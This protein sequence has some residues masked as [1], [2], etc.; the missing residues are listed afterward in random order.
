MKSS[1][2]KANPGK[3]RQNFGPSFEAEKHLRLFCDATS[4]ELATVL[5]TLVGELDYALSTTNSAAKERS[6]LTAVA[7]AER[8]LSLARNLRY[9][10]VHTQLNT[11]IHDVSQ[12]VLDSVELVEKELE[13]F[14]IKITVLAEAATYGLVDAGA[15]QQIVLNLLASARRTMPKGGTITLSLRRTENQIELK[16]ADTGHGIPEREI[17]TMFEPYAGKKTDGATPLEGLFQVHNL[18]LSVSKALV[19]AHGGDITVDSKVGMGTA[20]SINIPYDPKLVR[21][22]P[23]PEERRFRRIHLKMPVE[24]F[25]SRGQTSLRTELTT[26]SIGGCFTR[27]TDSIASPLPEIN[28]SLSIRIHYFGNEVLEIGRCRIASVSWAGVHSGLGIEFMELDGRGRKVLE[29][30]VKSHSS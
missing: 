18:G 12:I 27:I 25:L 13:L 8:A 6:T 19:D 11:E 9:F 30:I 29:A 4:H 20:I 14:K 21:I 22:S 1:A 24:L 15:I 17:E 28:D 7:A 26:L 10:S 3:N 5:G 16:C 2:K 23:F